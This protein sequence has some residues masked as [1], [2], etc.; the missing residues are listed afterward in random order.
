MQESRVT[1][2]KS[3]I[4]EDESN[5]LS[6]ILEDEAS[7]WTT[8]LEWWILQDGLILLFAYGTTTSIFTQQRKKLTTDST[9]IGRNKQGSKSQHNNSQT[10]PFNM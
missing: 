9:N 1:Y 5:I 6:N 8:L 10:H 4:L 2:W 7:A 3:N